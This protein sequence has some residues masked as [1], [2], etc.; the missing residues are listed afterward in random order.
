MNEVMKLP[1]GINYGMLVPVER[2]AQ[3]QLVT[4]EIVIATLN[5]QISM[6]SKES[7]RYIAGISFVT[8]TQ[9]KQIY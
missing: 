5:L 2:K 8:G 4:V 3:A 1:S 7:Y 6:A 9:S